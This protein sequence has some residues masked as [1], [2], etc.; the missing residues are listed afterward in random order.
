MRQSLTR[1]PWLAWNSLCRPGWLQADRDLSA[2][3]SG[4]GITRICYA[5][6]LPPSVL[7]RDLSLSLESACLAR[8]T[9]QEAPGILFLFTVLTGTIATASFLYGRWES[10][11]SLHTVWQ[12]LG[13]QECVFPDRL[14]VSFT[15]LRESFSRSQ[16]LEGQAARKDPASLR[17]P[18]CATA[19]QGA[20][21]GPGNKP[22]RQ[23]GSSSS[24]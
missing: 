11:L 6:W 19:W 8:L 14:S 13:G 2:S 4:S 24:N 22:R 9:D 3:G 21:Q 23:R 5:A 20:S 1:L 18:P 12:A 17:A 16:R 7:S 15:R 10:K